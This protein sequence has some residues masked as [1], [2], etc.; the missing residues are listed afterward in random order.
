MIRKLLTLGF[1]G[2]SL[3][4]ASALTTSITVLP[5]TYT[6]ALTLIN[7]SA[8]VSQVIV[9]STTSTNTSVLL[10]DAPTNQLT[11]IVPAYTNRVSYATNYITSWT[12]YYQVAQ[13]DTN[14]ALIDVTN[15]VQST[16]NTWPQRMGLASLGGSATAFTGVNY[17]FNNGIWITNTGSGTAN[18]TI[19]YQQ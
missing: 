9:S 5:G 3:V 1:L 6:N 4:G 12:N 2:L 7:G 17:Y 10:I 13:S 18:V 16:T 8:R 14:I 11:Y 15:L 19:T